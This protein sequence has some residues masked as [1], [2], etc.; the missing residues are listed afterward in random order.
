MTFYE[1]RYCLRQT[2][3]YVATDSLLPQ[4]FTDHTV[5]NNS[6]SNLQLLVNSD[7]TAVSLLA[8]WINTTVV[9]RKYADLLGVTVQVPR[10]VAEESGGLCM[11][12]P[13]Q[14]FFDTLEFNYQL[15]I[16]SDCTDENVDVITNCFFGF[17]RTTRPEFYGIDNATY[18][19]VC[20]YSLWRS[21]STGSEVL[22]FLGA[23]TD[24]A[25]VLP[26]VQNI[27]T[28]T[29]PPIISIPFP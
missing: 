18:A 5:P 21:N 8:S 20:I 13:A 25:N 12:C 23:V 17:S 22:S 2:K 19:D 29:P 27:A 10:Y 14:G 28:P 11:G 7:G 15:T 1:N 9:I 3:S 16:D 4:A 6:Y 26:N 24:D